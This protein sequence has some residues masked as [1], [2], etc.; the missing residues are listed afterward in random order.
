M[1]GITLVFMSA[2]VG[3]PGGANLVRYWK[4]T[5]SRGRASLPVQGSTLRVDLDWTG[6]QLEDNELASYFGEQY[7]VRFTVNGTPLLAR[8]RYVDTCIEN[9][10]KRVHEMEHT[11]RDGVCA[12]ELVKAL[13][14][15]QVFEL[16]PDPSR[17]WGRWYRAAS[18]LERDRRNH[19]IEIEEFT[20]VAHFNLEEG[21]VEIARSSLREL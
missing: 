7:L 6:Y 16:E 15:G 9:G 2:E 17:P 3:Y 18:L 11:S 10:E 19:E 14:E 5:G 12:T 4:A 20:S 13:E 8:E 21:V 1:G